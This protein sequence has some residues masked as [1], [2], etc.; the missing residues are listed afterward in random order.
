VRDRLIIPLLLVLSSA[1]GGGEP[2]P[3][4]QWRALGGGPVPATWSIAD[5]EIRHVPGGGDIRTEGQYGDFA[6]DFDWQISPNGNSG[7]FYRAAD[8]NSL[9]GPEYQ[10]LDNAGH[11]DGTAP[12]TSAASAFAVYAPSGDVTKPVG[13]W[14]SG[15]IVVTGN[16]VEHWLNGVLVLSYELGSPDW[17]TRV[18]ASKFRGT[19][20]GQARAGYIVLQ[21]H[22]DPVAYR[23]LA[24]TTLP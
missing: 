21:D 23:N 9:N 6:L 22:G 3:L 17:Q 15:R 12:L 2:E 1:A 11:P 14:N 16:H 8:G 7:V 10:I 4:T 13:E 24:I 18:A 20:Y 19:G 5:G